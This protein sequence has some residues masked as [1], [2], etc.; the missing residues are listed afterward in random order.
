MPKTKSAQCTSAMP[1]VTIYTG[2]PGPQGPPGPMGPSGAGGSRGPQ[3]MQGVPGPTGP[4][5]EDGPPGPAGAPG[6]NGQPRVAI[7]GS[8]TTNAT[9]FQPGNTTFSGFLTT[10]SAQG[11]TD[12]PSGFTI[13]T[14]GWYLVNLDIFTTDTIMS[15]RIWQMQNATIDITNVRVV[16]YASDTTSGAGSGSFVLL[17]D[18]GDT[19]SWF[20]TD[21]SSV[22]VPFATFSIACI[23]LP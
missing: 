16:T 18:A 23:G 6:L 19:I 9:M 13:L 7:G 2:P 17:F 10:I 4:Q 11:V 21:S 5:G 20:N 3:G 14:A 12:S 8:I 22:E 15:Q 1:C